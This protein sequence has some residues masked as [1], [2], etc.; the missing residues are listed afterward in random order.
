MLAAQLCTAICA[1]LHNVVTTCGSAGRIIPIFFHSVYMDVSS[2]GYDLKFVMTTAS[3]TVARVLT[4]RGASGGNSLIPFAH[5]MSD[6]S[7]CIVLTALLYS[8]NHAV[9]RYIITADCRTG[10][11]E[12]ILLKRIER[13][14]G[15]RNHIM[16]ATYFFATLRTI[17]HHIVAAIIGTIRIAVILLYRVFVMPICIEHVMLAT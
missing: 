11:S 17:D 3:A 10:R 16:L 6:R 14:P 4:V 15:C 9:G 5:F 13:M 8:A 12:R 2:R 7:K 1:V